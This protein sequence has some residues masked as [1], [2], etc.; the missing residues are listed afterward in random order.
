MNNRLTLLSSIA[1]IALLSFVAAGCA[2]QSGGGGSGG[3]GGQQ[4]SSQGLPPTVAIDAS[5]AR[6]MQEIMKPLIAH[7]D[8]P[9]PA[10]QVRLQVWDDK[11]IN[12]AN[13]G[14]GDFYITTGLLN[15]GTDNQIRAIM[16]H[17]VAHAD[18]GHVAR[19][20][21][22]ATGI[23]LGISLLDQIFP[24]A[25]ALTPIAGQLVF[26]AYS[27]G[28]ETSADAHGKDILDRAG[29]PGKELMISTL[30][31]LGRE[32]GS[33]GGFFSTHPATGDRL[34]ALE[35]MPN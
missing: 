6:R 20:Q 17:E 11:E 3:G 12:A 7:M 9:L 4:Q 15:R 14:G 22:V 35:R 16:A 13:A 30:T 27:R 26:S 10:N 28:E 18:L 24:G 29:Y 2:A 1:G 25:Q 32:S 33:G 23:G 5:Q 34:A 31:W 8:R 21:G 19:A